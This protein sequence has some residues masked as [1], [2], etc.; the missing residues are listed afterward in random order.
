[1]KKLSSYLAVLVVGCIVGGLAAARMNRQTPAVPTSDRLLSVELS[2]ALGSLEQLQLLQAGSY[3]A[4]ERKL[5]LEF[6]DS[7]RRAE[8]LTA[9]GASLHNFEGDLRALT[10]AVRSAMTLVGLP[11]GVARDFQAVAGRLAEN[12]S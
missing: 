8:K 10:P 12:A 3:P 11:S 5:A 6:Q 1:M 2:C 9:E 4:V 7:L